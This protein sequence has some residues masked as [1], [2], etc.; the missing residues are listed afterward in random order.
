MIVTY[1]VY[2]RANIEA[3]ISAESPEEAF[4][5]LIRMISK[6]D[7]MEIEKD[8]CDPEEGYQIC[9]FADVILEKKEENNE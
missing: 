9:P 4:Q 2:I 8:G 6:I 5:E 7:S 1:K 3:S